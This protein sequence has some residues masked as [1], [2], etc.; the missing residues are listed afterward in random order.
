MLVK[1]KILSFE[2]RKKKYF[3]FLRKK[4]TYS[5]HIGKKYTIFY[6]R[7]RLSAL[8]IASKFENY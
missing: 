2:Q 1:E 3:F 8:F 5:I 4:N 7:D 6:L